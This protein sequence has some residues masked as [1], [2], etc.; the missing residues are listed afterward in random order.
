VG[1][2]LVQQTIAALSSRLIFDD[3]RP[4]SRP[5]AQKFALSADL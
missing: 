4:I 3:Y 5:L 2:E 1:G